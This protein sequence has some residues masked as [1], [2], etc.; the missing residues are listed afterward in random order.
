MILVC[1][2]GGLSGRGDIIVGATAAAHPSVVEP[3][4]LSLNEIVTPIDSIQVLEQRL[5]DQDEVFVN[6]EV[7]GLSGLKNHIVKTL[8]HN[9]IW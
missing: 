1:L 7:T 2:G 5:V 4:L 9:V 8:V 6:L 3:E